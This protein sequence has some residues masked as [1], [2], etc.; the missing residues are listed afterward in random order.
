MI[1]QGL[2]DT[3]SIE[4]ANGWQK[5]RYVT[6]PLL[7]PSLM[8]SA[9]I[10]MINSFKSYR[11]AFLLS[12]KHPH[13]SIYML[14]HFLNNNFENLNYARLAV[15]SVLTALPMIVV[16]VFVLMAKKFNGQRARN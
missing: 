8:F 15:A 16:A 4:G 5:L 9:V 13:E 3:A 1:P 14:Q 6:L 7:K 10:G 12:G 2:F 11:E